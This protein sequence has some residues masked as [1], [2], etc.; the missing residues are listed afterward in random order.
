MLKRGHEDLGDDDNDGNSAKSQ[1]LDLTILPETKKSSDLIVVPGTEVGM[2]YIS[3][4]VLLLSIFV[5]S[6]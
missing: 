1:K 5:E 4:F 3:K 2:R 6:F